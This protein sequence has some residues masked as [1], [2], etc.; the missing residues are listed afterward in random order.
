MFLIEIESHPFLPPAPPSHPSLNPSPTIKI[1]ASFSLIITSMY[2]C[3]YVSIQIYKYCLL[4]LFLL[5][6]CIW[7]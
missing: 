1:I 5:I 7:F 4:N 2:A 6:V 3:V